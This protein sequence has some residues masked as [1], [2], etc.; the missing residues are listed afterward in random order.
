MRR[1]GV[2]LQRLQAA[3]GAGVGGKLTPAAVLEAI[4]RRS[5]THYPKPRVVTLSRG[6]CQLALP[7]PDNRG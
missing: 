6:S 3:A 5:D 4:A 2:L 1:A 7:N